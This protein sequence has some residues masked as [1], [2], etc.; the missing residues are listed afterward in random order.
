[1]L[2][3]V[4]GDGEI[5]MAEWRQQVLAPSEWPMALVYH[6]KRWFPRLAID[7]YIVL[8]LVSAINA[9]GAEL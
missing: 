2:S 6:E 3:A 5:T 7:H 4:Q 1:M 8:Q 9:P